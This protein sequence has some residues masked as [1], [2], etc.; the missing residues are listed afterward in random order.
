MDGEAEYLRNCGSEQNNNSCLMVERYKTDNNAG[1]DGVSIANMG[2]DQNLAGTPTRLDDGTYT[3]QVNGGTITVSNGTVTSG[4]VKAKSIAAFSNKTRSGK[5][6]PPKHIRTRA[7]FQVR[8][9]RSRC[10]PTSRPTPRIP[11]P[12]ASPVLTKMAM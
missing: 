12:T 7:R 5:V 2:G 11:R 10:V 8:P 4:A 1:N 6:P 9:R 3:D